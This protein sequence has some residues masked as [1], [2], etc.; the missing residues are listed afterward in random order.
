MRLTLELPCHCLLLALQ[1]PIL[2]SFRQ[3]QTKDLS[4]GPYLE[5]IPKDQS[6]V[7]YLELPNLLLLL[8]LQPLLHQSLT[9]ITSHS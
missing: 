7:S 9:Y 6:G 8:D 4:G 3:F 2:P 5:P 1:L